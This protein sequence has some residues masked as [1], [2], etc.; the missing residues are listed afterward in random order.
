MAYNWA[1]RLRILATLMMI[2]VH[3]SGPIAEHYGDYDTIWWWT[4]NIWDA[5]CRPCV[6]LFVMLSGYLLF[7]KTYPIGDFFKKRALRVVVPGFIWGAIYLLFTHFWDGWP[8]NF[9]QAA[10]Q[11]ITG[12]MHYH[13]WFIYLIIGLYACYP[14]MSPWVRQARD[15]DFVVLFAI[16]FIAVF[17]WKALKELA[18]IGMGFQLEFFC[19]HLG[20]FVGGYYFGTKKLGTP[21]E[22]L[23]GEKIV[24]WSFSR[25]KMLFLS[26]FCIVFGSLVTTFGTYFMGRETAIF[27]PYFY[28]YLTP[29]VAISTLGWFLLL[30]HFFNEKPLNNLES[31]FAKAS[32]GMY[33]CHVLVLYVLNYDLIYH[34]RFHPL[35]D[36]PM[37]VFL[38]VIE[39]FVFVWLI[40]RTP[41][42]KWLA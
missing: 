21:S 32:Y 11:M 33:L 12:P 1:D 9:G 5:F 2:S 10:T 13:L 39:S 25:Q 36:I 38:C 16:I 29:N 3:V 17:A 6:P 14:F 4:S 34:S 28:D 35:L 37:T 30:R 18:N 7:Q 31:D 20:Y 26:V 19:N 24:N 22:S 8:A 40:Q 42:G 23:M 41:L 27:H 15:A